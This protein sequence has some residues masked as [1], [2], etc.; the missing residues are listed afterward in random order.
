MF[1]RG[2]V[3]RARRALARATGMLRG[4]RLRAAMLAAFLACISPPALAFDQVV[5]HS[6]VYA[7]A[8]AN[9]LSPEDAA[10]V[11]NGS[12]SLDENDTTTAFSMSLLS[13]E[14]RAAID[15]LPRGIELPMKIIEELIELPHMRSGQVFHAL[16][17]P[18]NRKFVQQAHLR[19]INRVL[20][21]PN[22][23][24][25]PEQKRKRA[26]LYL[27]EYLHFVGDTVVHPNE[28]LLGHALEGHVPDRGD[29]N[30]H[31]VMLALGLFGREITEFQRVLNDPHAAMSF[32]WLPESSDDAAKRAI[33]PRLAGT[34]QG[35]RL[36]V[37]VG[38]AVADSWQ[39]TYP[40]YRNLCAFAMN[41]AGA[42][43]LLGDSLERE[44]T[45]RAAS[46]VNRILAARMPQPDVQRFGIFHKFVLDS[47][48]EPI[49]YCRAADDCD[50][51]YVVRTFGT[52][53]DINRLPSTF[54]DVLADNPA[55]HDERAAAVSDLLNGIRKSP[56]ESAVR[57]GQLVAAGK[58][59]DVITSLC[60]LKRSAEAVM[61][62]PPARASG[63][64]VARLRM[65]NA[66]L[67]TTIDQA[68]Q[69]HERARESVVAAAREPDPARRR[70]REAE[71]RRALG[72]RDGL[73]VSAARQAGVPLAP[74]ANRGSALQFG[75][76]PTLDLLRKMNDEYKAEGATNPLGTFLQ[77]YDG[78]AKRTADVLNRNPGTQF[79]GIP[80]AA[81]GP[82]PGSPSTPPPVAVAAPGRGEPGGIK[83]SS[84]RA[85]DIAANIDVSSIAFDAARG[86]IVASGAQGSETFDLD[87]FADVLRLA[88][89]EDEPFFS[90]DSLDNAAWDGRGARV[91]S[92]LDKKYPRTE[93]LIA[94]VR[95]VSPP[96]LTRGNRQYFYTTIEAL[97]PD[98]AE[99]AFAGQNIATKLVF[100]PAWLRYSKVGRILYEADLAIKA[101]ATGFVEQDGAIVPVPAIWN[102]PGYDPIWAQ[103]STGAAGRANFELSRAKVTGEAGRIDLAEVHPELYVTQRQTGTD[104]D[105]P[106][107]P[108]DRALTD[109]FS[110][111]WRAYADAVPEIGRL[112]TVF[113]AYVAAH[114]LI[115]KHPGLKARILSFPRELP[116]E[117][118]PVL[119][120][121]PLII[122]I[123]LE[124][125]RPA[126]IDS[127]GQYAYSLHGGYGGGIA[128]GITKTDGGGGPRI[129]VAGLDAAPGNWWQGLFAAAWYDARVDAAESPQGRSI[130]LDFE[131]GDMPMSWHLR[132]LA[133]AA[134]LSLG[135]I[136]F[137]LL[138]RRFDWQRIEIA[139]ACVHCARVH[140]TLGR[141]AAAADVVAAAGL[142][143][144]VLLPLVASAYETP[145]GWREAGLA[146][147][148]LALLLAVL[149]LLG[150]VARVLLD[151][152]PGKAPRSVGPISTMCSGVRIAGFCVAVLLFHGGFG[153]AGVGNAVAQL[154]TPPVAE[155]IFAMAGGAA[156]V[157]IA[158]ALA[159]GAAAVSLASRWLLPALLG[160]RPLALFSFSAPHTHGAPSP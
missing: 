64:E 112:V 81:R 133:A 136:A 25:T 4:T 124:N 37:D 87:V 46:E 159:G 83:F 21:D 158:A 97:D 79:F 60:G 76:S 9:G 10:I 99:R 68:V 92:E 88:V 82:G 26:L 3:V 145:S 36:L 95:R 80:S 121:T 155:R 22:E 43:A 105:L 41:E 72:A 101:V 134:V 70:E 32:Q 51:D 78:A 142:G 154:L 29:L 153:V 120:V 17:S 84:A 24:G 7:A 114:L 107:H 102:L 35:Q 122:R 47:Q 106:P 1:P 89:E 73:L 148:L 129:V 5:H 69:W 6:L 98:L 65:V 30:F 113:R 33:P 14:A 127:G 66:N 53:R 49:A 56:V 137:A 15:R 115:D 63:A 58:L 55:L 151:F 150:L 100:S 123:A 57:V 156:P 141:V 104:R 108:R 50:A 11:A 109:H 62:R 27:G 20:T 103:P 12:Y 74:A 13:D 117:Q 61:A 91:M 28:P 157:A 139:Q 110:R 54:A 86:R 149:F 132:L 23:P 118:P 16:S 143:Y 45:A 77:N 39:R 138:L 85:A 146:A 40:E 111:N 42:G 48:G 94:A 135:G 67:T 52:A 119:I 8:I 71:A 116:P 44:R 126:T 140:A 128:F 75:R 93:D 34:D 160:S 130:A 18:Q 2:G 96:P 59:P 125:G 90:L 31:A 144:L 131:G 147:G 38:K 19:R 152:T